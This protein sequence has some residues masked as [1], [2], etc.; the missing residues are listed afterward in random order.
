MEL[1]NFFFPFIVLHDWVISRPFHRPKII[2]IAFDYG[3]GCGGGFNW[4]R[5]TQF[6]WGWTWS[7]HNVFFLIVKLRPFNAFCFLIVELH[8]PFYFILA[9]LKCSK[10]KIKACWN[11]TKHLFFIFFA[12]GFQAVHKTDLITDNFMVWQMVQQ[13]LINGIVLVLG[14]GLFPSQVIQRANYVMKNLHVWTQ[15]PLRLRIS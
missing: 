8:E 9:T 6:L 2:S 5:L 10:I 3:G 13:L 1:F 15:L 14:P 11:N 7:F 4:I 12:I